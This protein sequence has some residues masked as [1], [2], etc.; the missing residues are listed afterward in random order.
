MRSAGGNSAIE[1]RDVLRDL[2]L[3]EAGDV[4]VGEHAVVDAQLVDIAA[5]IVAVGAFD[6]GGA[7]D[8][9]V[10]AELVERGIEEAGGFLGGHQ[11]AVD[12]KANAAGLVPCER[13]MNPLVGLGN[14]R[15][16]VTETRVRPRLTSVT[17]AS[18]PWPFQSMR[19][20]TM[21]QLEWSAKPTRKTGNSVSSTGIARAPEERERAALRVDVARRPV[22]EQLIVAALDVG[23]ADAVGK[24]LDVVHVVGDGIAAGSVVGVEAVVA[25]EIKEQAGL[26]WRADW[27]AGCEVVMGGAYSS[28]NLRMCAAAKR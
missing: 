25:G 7:D 17:K 23:A 28:G 1:W 13:E 3:R 14:V 27:A 19:S 20:Q 9:R 16:A 4:V 11:F 18:K 10:R 22:G 24:N 12:V 21:S 8:A 15:A 6:A 2:I 26:G 5:A